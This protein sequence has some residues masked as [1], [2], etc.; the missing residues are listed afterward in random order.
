MSLK[1]KTTEDEGVGVHSLL[2]ST[3]GVKEHARTPIW[4]LGQGTSESIIHMDL[5]K[6]NN[7]LVNA[8]LKH[9]WCT[10]ESWA[11]IDS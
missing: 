10:N 2:C 3:S 4:V 6:P 11:Y 1:V 8:W 5:Y 9:L 7:K